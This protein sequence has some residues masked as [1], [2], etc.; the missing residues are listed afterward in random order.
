MRSLDVAYSTK[1]QE[2]HQPI[3]PKPKQLTWSLFYTSKADAPGASWWTVLQFASASLLLVLA[4][5]WDNSVYFLNFYPVLE[6]SLLC[7]F[8]FK[9]LLQ[10]ILVTSWECIHGNY[11]FDPLLTSKYL[12]FYQYPRDC[13]NSKVEIWGLRFS[14]GTCPCFVGAPRSSLASKIRTVLMK[15]CILLCYFLFLLLLVTG[16]WKGI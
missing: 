12:L 15:M 7:G 5:I 6:L 4:S 9:I 11:I 14:D 1:G 10:C 8:P 16:E 2:A 3:A 13:E